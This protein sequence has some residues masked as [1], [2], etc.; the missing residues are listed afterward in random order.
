MEE[1]RAHEESGLAPARSAPAPTRHG[2][3]LARPV[4]LAAVALASFSFVAIVSGGEISSGLQQMRDVIGAKER[5]P[6]ISA[7]RRL[8]EVGWFASKR[9]RSERRAREDAQFAALRSISD[10]AHEATRAGA[11]PIENHDR[12][13]LIKGDHIIGVKQRFP[14]AWAAPKRSWLTEPAPTASS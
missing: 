5:V 12:R 7:R 6:I 11:E 1:G 13:T 9:A 2:R 10:V 14:V 4:F 8:S 3:R